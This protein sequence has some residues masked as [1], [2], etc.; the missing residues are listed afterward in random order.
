M[1]NNVPKL[2]IELPCKV[3]TLESKIRAYCEQNG[4]FDTAVATVSVLRTVESY[5]GMPRLEIYIPKKEN[6]Q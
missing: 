4:C 2:V 3:S 5:D 1:P 6:A